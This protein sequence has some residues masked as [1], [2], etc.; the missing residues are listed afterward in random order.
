MYVHLKVQ[1]NNKFENTFRPV[2]ETY[3]QEW[4]STKC[5]P[6]DTVY[7][8]FAITSALCKVLAVTK[9]PALMKSSFC[10]SDGYTNGDDPAAVCKDF[11]YH[12]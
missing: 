12:T 9:A 5:I 2:P 11:V 1:I 8:F 3:G 7:I 10:E 4:T 6:V